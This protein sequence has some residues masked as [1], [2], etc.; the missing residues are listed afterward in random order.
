MDL[1]RED[2]LI[3]GDRNSNGQRGGEIEGMSLEVKKEN[4]MRTEL[5]S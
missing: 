4:R 2:S 3:E 1:T 5:T